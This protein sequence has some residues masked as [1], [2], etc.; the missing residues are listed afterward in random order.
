MF[1]DKQVVLSVCA[2]LQVLDD[3]KKLSLASGELVP[4]PR[5]VSFVFE[6]MDLSLASPA[7][8]SRCGMVFM[9]PDKITPATLFQSWLPT[10]PDVLRQPANAAVLQV[11]AAFML[12]A[13][14]VTS[15]TPCVC[16]CVCVLSGNVR[17]VGFPFLASSGSVGIPL[18]RLCCRCWGR[19]GSCGFHAPGA[20]RAVSGAHS[21]CC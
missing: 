10:I 11:S 5:L 6:T 12:C 21:P 9:E 2:C 13:H 4:L 20:R 14:M 7:T 17:L 18:A 1:P 8:V 19:L 16:V 15:L 3:T